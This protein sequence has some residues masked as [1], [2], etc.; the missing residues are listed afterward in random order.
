MFFGDRFDVAGGGLEKIER[1]QFDVERCG[2]VE[3]ECVRTRRAFG[4][5]WR[6]GA[7][8][9][10]SASAAGS[11]AGDRGAAGSVA[12]GSG[13]IVAAGSAVPV[14]VGIAVAPGMAQLDS[15]AA[16]AGAVANGWACGAGVGAMGGVGVA[17]SMEAP[18]T[19]R[20]GNADADWLAEVGGAADAVAVGP[21][22][23]TQAR[24]SS[25]LACR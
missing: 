9:L 11:A 1:R 16:G 18:G 2:R 23:S 13:A 21:R 7:G 19:E 25:R 12:A 8:A 3:F 6:V 10:D 15:E 20:V 4:C 24:R 14:V 17:A 22:R 5:G